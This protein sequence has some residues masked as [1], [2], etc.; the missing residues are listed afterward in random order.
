MIGLLGSQKWYEARY[1]STWVVIV[2]L[3]LLPLSCFAFVHIWSLMIEMCCQVKV[4][5][6]KPQELSAPPTNRTIATAPILTKL[7]ANFRFA[8][9]VDEHGSDSSNSS[10]VFSLNSA[11]E[12]QRLMAKWA[13]CPRCACPVKSKSTKRVT[14]L[15]QDIIPDNL[16][17]TTAQTTKVAD[18][19]KWLTLHNTAVGR[20]A[21]LVFD[22]KALESAMVQVASPPETIIT[23]TDTGT[24]TGTHTGT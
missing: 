21:P 12:C 20:G 6:A 2:Y 10:T 5:V 17:G 18:V 11:I 23:V 4:E 19:A 16:G 9:Y 1:E 13:P 24:Y 22:T 14:P 8:N 7:P 15:P 3:I